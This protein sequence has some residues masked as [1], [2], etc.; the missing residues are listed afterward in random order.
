MNIRSFFKKLGIAAMLI[1]LATG[2]Q[3]CSDDKESDGPVGTGTVSGVVCDE[4]SQPIEG[5]AVSVSDCEATD[6]TDSEGRYTLENVPMTSGIVSFSKKDYATVS[7]TIV[8]AKFNSDR[9]ATVSPIMEYAGARIRGRVFD[10]FA[11]GAPLEGMNVRVSDSQQTQTAADGTFEIGELTLANYEVTFSKEGYQTKTVTVSL[12]D[13]VDGVATIPDFTM[14]GKALLGDLTIGDIKALRTWYFNEYRGGRNADNY[15]HWDWACNYMCTLDFFGNWEEQ[16]EG[17]TVRIRNNDDERNRPTDL[18][19]FDSFVAG[20]KVL[21]ADNCIMTL[22]MR[23]HNAEPDAPAYYGVKVID[24]T[25]AEPEAVL[26]GGV[27]TFADSNYLTV[28]VDLSAYVGK[29]ICIAVGIFRQQPGD[30]WKQLVIRSIFFSKEPVPGYQW[31]PGIPVAGLE[32]WELTQEAVRS[33]MPHSK[34]HFTGIS[35]VSGNRDNYFDAYRAWRD[36]SHIASEWTFIPLHKDPEVFPGEGYLIKTRSDARISTVEPESYYYAKFAVA[37]GKNHMT[38]RTRNFGGDYTYFKVTAIDEDCNVTYLSPVANT[39]QAAEAAAD[40]C[41]KF[42]HDS[43]ENGKPDSYA[44]FEYDLSR[45]NGKNVVIAISIH[46]GEANG[47]EN[48]LVF[49]SIDFD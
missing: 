31:L 24:L 35:P 11:G 42:I 12:G 38:F 2:S 1:G 27:R 48:K 19:E 44:A 15:P 28:P 37:P 22:Q 41:W 25:A 30:Y 46:M 5:V 47:N 16:N 21:T 33:I 40:G 45:F 9:Q 7:V 20:R 23:T 43:G 13:F 3:S 8:K 26:V 4:F 18:K 36:V 6:I 32:S 29:E 39:A 17:T 14:G 49:Y 10:G 34:S